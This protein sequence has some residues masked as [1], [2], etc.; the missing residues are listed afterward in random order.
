[1][2]LYKKIK[3]AMSLFFRFTGMEIQVQ[4]TVP[5]SLKVKKWKMIQMDLSIYSLVCHSSKIMHHQEL[6]SWGTW[7]TRNNFKPQ[8]LFHSQNF[9]PKFFH[10]FA[11]ADYNCTRRGGLVGNTPILVKF[12]RSQPSAPIIR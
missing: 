4:P 11:A 2:L 7:L 1:M 10:F 9:D 5:C 8:C 12:P 3:I 6:S